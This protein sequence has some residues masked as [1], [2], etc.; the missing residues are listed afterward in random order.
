MLTELILTLGIYSNFMDI[1]NEIS[2]SRIETESS[3]IAD[4]EITCFDEFIDKELDEEQKK[5]FTG[6]FMETLLLKC[7]QTEIDPWLVISIIKNESN[8][9]PGARAYDG[10]HHY[11]LMQLSEYYFSD[12]IKLTESQDFFEPVANITVGIDNLHNIQEKI[13]YY[14]CLRN[15]TIDDPLETLTVMSHNRGMGEAVSK[16]KEGNINDFTLSVLKDSKEYKR[17]YGEIDCISEITET[18]FWIK[19]NDH[20]VCSDCNKI[21]EV[22]ELNGIPI[23]QYCPFCGLEKNLH[24]KKDNKFDSEIHK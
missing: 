14:S 12:E 20:Y 2:E 17:K 22:A 15:T 9:N 23:Y 6:D 21:I 4:K 3:L 13:R 18:G 7:A 11:G 16:F 1:Q 10:S 24:Y 8:F 19:L 5:I